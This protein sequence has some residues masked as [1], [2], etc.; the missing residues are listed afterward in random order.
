MKF[1]I[2]VPHFDQSISDE[3]FIRG[4]KCLLDQTLQD[5]EVLIYHD[6]PTV[7]PIPDIW[8]QLGERAKLEVTSRREN[9]WG[10]G[11]RD[12]G[13]KASRGHYIV[14]FNPDNILYSFA[15]EEI[16]KES[17]KPYTSF[18][19]T[20][21]LIVFPVLMRGMQSNGKFL[22]RDTENPGGNYMV[23]N[24]YPPVKNNIDAMQLVMTGNLWDRYN[25]WYDKSK[26]SDGNM[27]PRFIYE[28]GARYCSKILGEHW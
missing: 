1:S 5:F 9:N 6:G 15:L 12:R 10:H 4:M 28:N 23:F 8:K 13:I 14:H 3:T 21:N 26:E 20:K 18:P 2:I 27:Y 24:G 22:F 19:T 7:R 16:I 17:E 11:N 25:G